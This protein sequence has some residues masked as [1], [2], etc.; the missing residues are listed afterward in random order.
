MTEMD[1]NDPSR[2]KKKRNGR[3]VMLQVSDALF[4]GIKDTAEAREENMSQF[5]RACILR[6]IRSNARVKSK[7]AQV[8]ALLAI[9]CCL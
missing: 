3:M 9:A 1:F 5:I 6:G 4:A 7:K 2:M 8:L